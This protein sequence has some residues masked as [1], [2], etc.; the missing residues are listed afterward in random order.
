MGHRKYTPAEDRTIREFAG[1]KTA[2][3]IGLMIDRPKNG[4]HHR[5]HKLGLKGH[6]HGQHHWNA[7]LNNL[8]VSMITTLIDAGF[9]PV[10]VHK[11]FSEPT[12]VSH[13]TIKCIAAGIYRQNG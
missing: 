11:M 10:E 9:S 13:N 2:E 8:Q 6:I 5:I 1:V 12:N 4:V 3:E 7:K